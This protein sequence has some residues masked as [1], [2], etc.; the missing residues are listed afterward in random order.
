[1]NEPSASRLDLVIQAG[2]LILKSAQ[3][4]SRDR[5]SVRLELRAAAPL[6]F[7]LHL[8]AVAER[9]EEV[10]LPGHRPLGQRLRRVGRLARPDAPLVARRLRFLEVDQDRRQALL[11][12]AAREE[13]PVDW[14]RAAAAR[15]GEDG[16]PGGRKGCAARGAARAGTCG[17][18]GLL[19]SA[20]KLEYFQRLAPPTTMLTPESCSPPG[21]PSVSAPDESVLSSKASPW[22]QKRIRP[23]CT[24]NRTPS[25][26][27]RTPGSAPAPQRS[28]EPSVVSST[29]PVT[30]RIASV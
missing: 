1:M 8:L 23:V 10:H 19:A 9:R 6:E 30:K 22:K 21:T 17:R 14:W 18:R 20:P 25:S 16:G 27:I 7:R 28:E 5:P 15:G 3:S 26:R 12:P 4:A 29:P 11:E 13:V 24:V 2:R